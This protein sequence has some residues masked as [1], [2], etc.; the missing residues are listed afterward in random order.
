MTSARPVTV[1]VS[2]GSNIAPEA[3]LRL[4]YRELQRRYGHVSVSP[5]YRTPAVGFSGAPFLNCVFAYATEE[6]APA[7][8]AVL[9]EIHEL[10]GRVRGANPFSAR[11]LDLDLLLYADQVIPEPPVKVP[12]DDI[13]QYAFVLKPLADL[14]PEVRH[15]VLGKSIQLLWQEFPGR[16]APLAPVDLDLRDPG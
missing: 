7:V 16:D 2:V 9:E 6:P 4:A 11:T 14:A 1:Y 12:R 3:N 8:V 15:P 13:T 5:I 10:V